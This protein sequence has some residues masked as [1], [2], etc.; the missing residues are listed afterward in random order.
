EDNDVVIIPLEVARKLL[1]ETENVTTIEIFIAPNTP[2]D[3]IKKDMEKALGK[4]FLVKDRIQQN[5]LLYKILNSEKW[6]VYLILTFVLIIA[7]F[8]IIG[9]L[10]MLVIDKRKD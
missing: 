2:I 6:A 4:D 5:A 9:S 3:K 1:G 8:N 10:T 7:I